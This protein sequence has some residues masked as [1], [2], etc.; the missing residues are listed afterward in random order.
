MTRAPLQE[1][2][3]TVKRLA[4]IMHSD[5]LPMN[6]EWYTF[7]QSINDL[8]LH[9]QFLAKRV[10]TVEDALREGEADLLATQLHKSRVGSRQVEAELAIAHSKAEAVTLVAVA[11]TKL[12][13]ASKVAQVT[14]MVAKL[15]ETLT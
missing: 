15:V 3:A 12:S 6:R 7:V 14:D 4:Q 2:A 5:L 9:H 1:H 8:G 10:A 11:T 13:T